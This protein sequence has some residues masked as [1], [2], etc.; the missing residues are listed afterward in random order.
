[1][2]AAARGQESLRVVVDVFVVRAR[3]SRARAHTYITAC[4]DTSEIYTYLP[5]IR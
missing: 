5:V 4:S 3:Y 1:M 2:L